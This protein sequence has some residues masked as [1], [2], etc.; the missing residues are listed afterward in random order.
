MFS[1]IFS[2]A[3]SRKRGS[4]YVEAAVVFPMVILS[5][6]LV[7]SIALDLY[8]RIDDASEKHREETRQELEEKRLYLYLSRNYFSFDDEPDTGGDSRSLC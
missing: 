3:G 5:A 6:A 1:R 7:I 8:E 4:S 2:K